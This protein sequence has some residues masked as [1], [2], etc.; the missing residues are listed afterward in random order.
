MNIYLDSCD[1]HMIRQLSNVGIID[2]VTTNP[3]MLPG[4]YKSKL[5]TLKQIYSIIT[6]SVSV[7]VQSHIYEEILNESYDLL[8]IFP[9]LTIKLPITKNGLQACKVLSEKSVKVNMTL[10][11]SASQALLA[12]KM[13]A[14]YVS[15]FVGRIDDT[16]SN[17]INI[18]KDICEIFSYYPNIS[19]KVLVASIRNDNHII[20]SLKLGVDVITLSPKLLLN[21]IDHPLTQ[22]G[23]C[24]FNQSQ[25]LSL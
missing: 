5:Y 15:V 20:N 16:G 7:Q 13:R 8:N 23:I 18:V 17:G 3:A 22:K 4:N 1:I 19:T 10:C 2:G 11:F 21:M 24:L 12:A 25:K 14:T 6:K 9:N